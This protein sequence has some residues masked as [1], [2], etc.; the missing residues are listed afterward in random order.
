MTL[1]EF[2]DTVYRRARLINASPRSIAQIRFC[3][4]RFDSWLERP[5]TLADLTLDKLSD[6]MT[7]QVADEL[8]VATI[9]GRIK[10]LTTLWRFALKRKYLTTGD[11]GEIELLKQPR[12]LAVAWTIDEIERLL[13]AC[14]ETPGRLV[15]IHAGK[16][17]EALVSLL[18]D[19]GLRRSAAFAIRVDEVDFNTHVLR[20]PAERMKNLCEQIFWLSDR[21]MAAILATFPP[22]RELLF[23]W[24]WKSTE[25]TQSRA[26]GK[27]LRRAGLPAGRRDLF[28]KLRRS[29]AS[30]LAAAAGEA[31]AIKQLGHSD[32]SCIRRYVDPRFTANHEAAKLLAR[33]GWDGRHVVVEVKPG[34]DPDTL[35]PLVVRMSRSDW[36]AEGMGLL[37][38]LRNRDGFTG[39]DLA[40]A[41]EHLG[42]HCKEFAEMV[43]TDRRNLGAILR[44][45]QQTIGKAL[46]QRIRSVLGLNFVFADQP[47]EVVETGGAA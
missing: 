45:K 1:R 33:P 5:A 31:V 18:F 7:W 32:A 19:T 47:A 2:F 17:W 16:Y 15:G 4:N 13:S 10:L 39:E 9:N 38:A 25:G 30:H 44:G 12:R 40:K 34:V 46:R 43:G 20:V 35:P 6:W 8:S 14:R 26:L 36:A 27:I 24:P 41:L 22:A 29:C 42:I 21:T 28:H 23:P 3:I 37:A 11:P